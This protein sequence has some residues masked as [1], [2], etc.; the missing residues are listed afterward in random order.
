MSHFPTSLPE[1]KAPESRRSPVSRQSSLCHRANW[2]PHSSSLNS[3]LLRRHCRRPHT[4]RSLKLALPISTHRPFRRSQL[5]A[6]PLN[7]RNWHSFA[8]DS[9]AAEIEDRGK[10]RTAASDDVPSPM[11]EQRDGIRLAFDSAGVSRRDADR[12]LLIGPGS[13]GSA[14]AEMRTENGIGTPSG[15]A[16]RAGAANVIMY[17][18]TNRL[19][20]QAFLFDRQNGLGARNPFTQWVRGDN[21]CIA[22]LDAS[23]HT[24]A[25]LAR[26]S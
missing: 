7:G 8:L 1:S 11:S 3:A 22:H 25:L 12:T 18:G 5:Q 6:L 23:I 14:I 21:A 13:G 19:H 16:A 15:D 17:R 10:A 20:G 9:P 24:D 2:V 4:R 26:R